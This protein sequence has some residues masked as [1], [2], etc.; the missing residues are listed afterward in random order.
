M[1]AATIR[2]AW[3]LPMCAPNVPSTIDEPSRNDDPDEGGSIFR[4]DSW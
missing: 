2:L 3:W 4:Q 1:S